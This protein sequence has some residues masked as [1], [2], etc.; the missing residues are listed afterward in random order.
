MSVFDHD[1]RVPRD[2][3][4]KSEIEIVVGRVRVGG[5]RDS[6]PTPLMFPFQ[7]DSVVLQF[8]FVFETLNGDVPVEIVEAAIKEARE[9]IKT[10]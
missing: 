10:K 7:G 2:G 3:L 8:V 5:N 1:D 9:R 6:P 4:F